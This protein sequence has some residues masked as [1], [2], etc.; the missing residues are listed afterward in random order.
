MRELDETTPLVRLYQ[1][2]YLL[3]F[4]KVVGWLGTGQS[5]LGGGSEEGILC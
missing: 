2:I 5:R 1:P 3:L 4:Q